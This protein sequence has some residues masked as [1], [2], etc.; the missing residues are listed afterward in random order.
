MTSQE[1]VTSK[2]HISQDLHGDMRSRLQRARDARLP[3]GWAV[4]FPVFLFF[5]FSF[6]FLPH[7]GFVCDELTLS[8]AKK[9]HFSFLPSHFPSLP[10]RR[11]HHGGAEIRIEFTLSIASNQAQPLLIWWRRDLG[12][13]ASKNRRICN[14]YVFKVVSQNLAYWQ[15]VTRVV[16]RV[17]G[18]TAERRTGSGTSARV[19]NVARLVHGRGDALL[20]VEVC[21]SCWCPSSWTVR[22]SSKK[23]RSVLSLLFVAVDFVTLWPWNPSSWR[24]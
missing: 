22:K 6:L 11:G 19:R 8:L 12:L 21:H 18:G 17:S 24:A 9:S 1:L 10:S 15:R 20:R 14:H 4:S 16:T 7:S 5:F 13:G 3:R 2:S 23:C